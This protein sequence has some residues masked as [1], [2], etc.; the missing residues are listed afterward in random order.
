[1]HR[2]PYFG[3]QTTLHLLF[4][5]V[6]IVSTLQR[7]VLE[8]ESSVKSL[9]LA[10]YLRIESLPK[11]LHSGFEFHLPAWLKIKVVVV[12]KLVGYLG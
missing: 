11:H 2:F 3:L 6:T 7:K 1:M 8:P 9:V 4:Q 5:N 12:D 10:L